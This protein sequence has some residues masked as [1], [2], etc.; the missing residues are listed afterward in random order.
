[1]I[2]CVCGG[3]PTKPIYNGQEYYIRCMNCGLEVND[4][5]QGDHVG[6][7]SVLEKWKLV[8]SGQYRREIHALTD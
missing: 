7:M 4:Y 8:M 3:T 5:D 6:G 2:N 1:M